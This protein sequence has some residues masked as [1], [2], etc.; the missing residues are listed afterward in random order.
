MPTVKKTH[1]DTDHLL[2]SF[3]HFASGSPFILKANE[4]AKGITTPT[5]PRYKVG[6]CIAKAGS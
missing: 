1:A 4:Q 5:Y 2:T 3:S 6:G